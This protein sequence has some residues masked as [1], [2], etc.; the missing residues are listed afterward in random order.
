VHDIIR[1]FAPGNEREQENGESYG[2]IHVGLR[3]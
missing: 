2:A 3:L 1:A